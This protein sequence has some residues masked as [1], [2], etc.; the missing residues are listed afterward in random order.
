MVFLLTHR[1]IMSIDIEYS[2]RLGKSKV[3]YFK[4]AIR[5]LS[6]VFMIAN[7]FQVYRLILILLAMY[8]SISI[9]WWGIGTMLGIGFA[10]QIISH[11]TI[12]FGF[13][14]A[15][16]ALIAMPITKLFIKTLHQKHD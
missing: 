12:V 14:M 1:S 10:S 7:H 8:I 4:D 6:Y 2:E 9:I 15:T 3:A 16:L 5:T 11:L 13:V